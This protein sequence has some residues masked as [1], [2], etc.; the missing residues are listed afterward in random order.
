MN[1]ALAKTEIGQIMQLS[2]QI[3]DIRE[4][5]GGLFTPL[6]REFLQLKLIIYSNLQEPVERAVKVIRANMKQILTITPA[7]PKQSLML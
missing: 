3:N 2:N 7:L 1:T 6:K 4:S 5:V